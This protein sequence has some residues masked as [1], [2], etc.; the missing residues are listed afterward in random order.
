MAYG[1]KYTDEMRRFILE[2]YRGIT[3][4]EL[5]A[6]FNEE[7]GT[8]V[9]PGQMK[10]YKGNHKLNS[11]LSGYFL[12]GHAPY[13][14]GKKMP[15]EMYEKV[16]HTMFK[17]G[18]IPAMHRPVGSERVTRDGYTE[19]KVQEPNQWRLKHN[20]IW[21]EHHGEIPE[22]SIVI[23]L[24]GDK[25]NMAIENLKMLKRS[26]LLIMNRYNLYGANA[27]ATEVGTNL[28]R[29]MDVTNKAKRNGNKDLWRL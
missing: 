1:R 26:E 27:E 29:L 2:N 23:F 24:D 8:D 21:E 20:V 19:I 14:K 25:T 11:G 10:A 28:A 4:R 15:P 7:F 9:T 18:H 3:S 12:A 17:K 6:K 13:N 22:G 5:A 16:K